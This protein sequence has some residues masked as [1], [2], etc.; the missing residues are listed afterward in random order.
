MLPHWYLPT[1]LQLEQ[2]RSGKAAGEQEGHATDNGL[3]V[4]QRTDPYTVI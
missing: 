4:R 2:N 3:C 1:S